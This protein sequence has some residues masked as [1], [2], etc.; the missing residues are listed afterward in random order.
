MNADELYEAWKERHRAIQ[1]SA[2]FTDRVMNGIRALP[3]PLFREG[4]RAE[5]ILSW[6]GNRK[7]A[8]AAVIA[9]TTAAA[10]GQGVILIRIAIG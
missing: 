3:A 4:G 5:S 9:L 10:L 7:W 1:P 8:Q 2:G 6:M